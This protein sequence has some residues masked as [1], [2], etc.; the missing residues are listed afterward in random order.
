MA[1]DNRAVKVDRILSRTFATIGG[2]WQV[3]LGLSFVLAGLPSIAMTIYSGAVTSLRPTDPQT[4]MAAVTGAV[5][6]GLGSVVAFVLLQGALVPA[7]LAQDAGRRATVGECLR[8]GLR[9]TL[10]LLGLNIL[11]GIALLLGSLLLLVPAIMLAILWAVANP[12]LVAER[13]GVFRAFGRSADLTRGARW[14]VF[15]MELLALVFI[16]I[17]SS[18][19]AILLVAFG[20][21]ASGLDTQARP[22]WYLAVSA[23]VQTAVA[24]FWAI[25]QVS[26]YIE[27]RDWKEGPQGAAL[28]EVFA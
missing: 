25:V 4:V 6:A 23:L 12:A 9:A 7:T 17:A 5:V 8:T 14:K 18:A 26:I 11:L 2:Q 13:T 16:W 20:A 15:G 27:L 21:G 24:A 19:L 22:L 28:A 1:V 3:V 10:P